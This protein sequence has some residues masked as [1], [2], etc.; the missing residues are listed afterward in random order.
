[1]IKCLTKQSKVRSLYIYIYQW[2]NL[3][4]IK[5]E[6]IKTQIEGYNL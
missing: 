6:T 3:S 5:Q 4:R 1:M 2:S